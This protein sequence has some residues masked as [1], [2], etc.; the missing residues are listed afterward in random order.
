MQ[1]FHFGLVKFDHQN[2]LL[3]IGI[4]SHNY[5]LSLQCG[6]EKAYCHDDDDDETGN[7][8]SLGVMVLKVIL[9]LFHWV[10]P[11]FKMTNP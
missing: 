10:T 6:I 9:T 8:N 4:L 1:L 3:D 2:I 11:K 7:C 5:G